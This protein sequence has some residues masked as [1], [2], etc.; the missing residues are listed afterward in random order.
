MLDL[1]FGL[2][3][4]V[5]PYN[6]YLAWELEEHPLQCAEWPDGQ[7]LACVSGLLDGE[8]AAIRVAFRAIERQCLAYDKRLGRDDLADA[9]N[10][11]GSQLDLHRQQ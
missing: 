6:K 7:L 2:C 9:I 1:V 10:D 11:W 5:R 4:R 3:G 8:E